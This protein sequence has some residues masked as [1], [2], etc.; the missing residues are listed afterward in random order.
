MQRNLRSLV[1]NSMEAT[2]GEIGSIQS[3]YFNDKNWAIRFLVVKTGSWLFGRSVL[4]SPVAVLR[5][6]WEGK[7]IPVNL[8]KAQVS[9]SP[10][11]DMHKTVSRQH[12]VELYEHYSWQPYWGS[13]FYAGGLWGVMP[14]APLFDEGILKETDS[15]EIEEN[16]I[17]DLHLRGTEQ[18]TGYHIQATDGE[19]GHVH[20]FIIDDESWQILYF[21]IDTH[22]FIGGKKVLLDVKNITDIQWENAKIILNISIEAVKDCRLFDAAQFDNSEV[23]DSASAQS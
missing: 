23:A 22:N 12:E 19:A 4:I 7:G 20:D 18:V 11:T 2:D 13:G 5:T 15:T 17:D 14:P 6:D 9:N 1:G 16:K 8:T 3:I 10:D 21:I